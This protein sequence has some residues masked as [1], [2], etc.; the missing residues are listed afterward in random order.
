LTRRRGADPGSLAGL[1]RRLTERDFAIID[2]LARHKVMTSL[3]LAAVFFP[4]QHTAANRLLTL[5]EMGVLDRELLPGSGAY[6][7]L[8]GWHGQVIHAFEHGLRP[9]TRAAAQLA[10]HQ[11]LFTSQLAHKEGVNSFF[12]RLH[13]A[14]RTRGVRVTEWLAEAEAATE[15]DNLRPDAAGTL[16]WDDGR[17]LR[18]WFEHD[19]GTETLGLL[20]AKLERYPHRRSI[21][22]NGDRVLLV[23]VK[24][25][26]RLANLAATQLD[27]G[28]ITAA[29]LLYQPIDSA[30]TSAESGA[31]LFDAE[32]WHRLEGPGVMCRLADLAAHR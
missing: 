27:L 24:G 23:E 13:Y 4:S 30:A 15:F 12:A 18:F 20:R 1:R 31:A 21:H 28:G 7:Y 22:L 17:D 26:R 5:T 19:R 25:A 9:P 10:S 29:A 16:T 32:T 2:A 8:L 11:I 3:M 14:G 6:R